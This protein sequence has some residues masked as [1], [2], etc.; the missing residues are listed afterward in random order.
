VSKFF[1][2]CVVYFHWTNIVKRGMGP[3]ASELI[4]IVKI[5]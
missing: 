5:T 1:N 4:G 2:H 3:E